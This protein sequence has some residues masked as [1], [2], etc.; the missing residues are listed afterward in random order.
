MNARERRLTALNN[1]ITRLDRYL[2]RLNAESEQLTRQR[3]GAFLVGGALA[4]AGLA[5]SDWLGLL[6]LIA[7][8][9]VFGML[10]ARHRRANAN[11]ERFTAW[12]AIKADQLARMTLDWAHISQTESPAPADHPF[13]RD[14]DIIGA[15]SVHRLLDTTV[16]KGGSRR[17]LDWLLTTTP[18]PDAIQKR[19]NAVRELIPLTAF[20]DKITLNGMRA[21]RNRRDKW[22]GERLLAWV[23]GKDDQPRIGAGTV[24]FLALLAAANITLFALNMLEIIPALWIGTFT[25][26]V[27]FSAVQWRSLGTLFDDAMMLQDQLGRLS[28]VL[29]YLESYPY[30]GRDS[31]KRLCAP[32]LEAGHQPSTQLKR[33]ARV[34]AAASLQRNPIVWIMLN[35]VIPWDVF[36]AYRLERSRDEMSDDLPRWLDA[37]YELEALSALATFAHLN[38][39]ATFPTLT[40]KATFTGRTLGHPLIP[41]DERI[42][43]DFALDELGRV[44]ILTGSNMSGKS[45]F[46]RT[47]GIN[48]SLAYAGGVVLADDLNAGLFRLFTCI[49]VADSVVDG[50]SYFY[51]EVRRLRALL[52]ALRDADAPPVFFLIDEIFRGTNN[53]ERLI[54]SRAYIRALTGE[55]GLGLI[56]T[57]DLELVK[58]ADDIPQISNYHFREEVIN[59]RMAFDYRLRTGPSPTTNALKIMQ[60]E[61]LPVDEVDLIER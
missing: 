12:R 11:I 34:A 43:N 36:F 30:H 32:L 2:K 29:D 53:R 27:L 21:A 52:E 25:V 5:V 41:H 7:A 24:T 6:A 13:A 40:P 61:G 55:N 20:R 44:V 45:S 19:Q 48:L 9:I 58:L 51:A 8:I 54:G 16:S 26:Y 39:A 31:I 23:R 14:I 22:N 57:H 17:L 49:R 10:V 42:C 37:W 33:I 60:M 47:L 38:P 50:F 3:L 4:L 46:L 1:H 15:Y 35:L 28:A 59:G 18:D 56:S